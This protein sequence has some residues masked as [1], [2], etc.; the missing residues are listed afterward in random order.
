MLDINVIRE[1]PELIKES[2]IK[3]GLSADEISKLIKLD[4]EWRELKT[5]VDELRSKRN[6]ISEEINKA[7]KEG[8]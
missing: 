7:K 1:K 2:Q 6:K 5:Q 8:S 3:R 4:K